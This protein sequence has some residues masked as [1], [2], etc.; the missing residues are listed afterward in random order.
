M[1]TNPNKVNQYTQPDPRQSVFLVGYLDPKSPTYS[2]AK[3][4]ALSAG[5]TEEYANNIL[6]LLPDWLSDALGD[7]EL[8]KK[9]EKRLKQI[10]ELEPVSE[11]GVVDNS[12]LANQMKA[13]T[14]VAKGLGKSKYSERQEHTG[15]DGKDLVIQFDSSFKKDVDTTQ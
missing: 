7:N 10:L 5:Y 12:L 14:L 2:N 3:Q 9:A 4:S 11:D 6:W 8:L 1:K 15:K 13:I